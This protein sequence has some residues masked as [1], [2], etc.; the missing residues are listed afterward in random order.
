MLVVG[1]IYLEIALPKKGKRV[2]VYTNFGTSCAKEPRMNAAAL[3]N[4]WETH[5]L[6]GPM[7]LSIYPLLEFLRCC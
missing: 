2:T 6:C 7:S 4:L 1:G 5:P 3:D